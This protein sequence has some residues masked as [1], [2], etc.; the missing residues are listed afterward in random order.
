MPVSQQNTLH[1]EDWGNIYRKQVSG[2]EE[3]I[4]E[5][6]VEDA[7]FFCAKACGNLLCA[8]LC[9]HS[10]LLSTIRPEIRLGQRKVFCGGHCSARGTTRMHEVARM[11]IFFSHVLLVH[12]PRGACFSNACFSCLTTKRDTSVGLV[13]HFH[14]LAFKGPCCLMH[15][16]ASSVSGY[17]SVQERK[18]YLC[19]ISK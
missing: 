1:V 19:W 7:L 17:S 2:H 16:F 8:H 14:R 4:S 11:C 13:W 3:N 10:L 5:I 9:Y 12:L 15:G 18:M 6:Q